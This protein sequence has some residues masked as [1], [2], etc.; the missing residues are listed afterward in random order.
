MRSFE[1][2]IAWLRIRRTL[3]LRRYEQVVHS[4]W[5]IFLASVCKESLLKFWLAPFLR[6][7]SRH[8]ISC[9][10]WGPDQRCDTCLHTLV[11]KF[12]NRLE[13][14]WQL[15]FEMGE[16]TTLLLCLNHLDRL[17]TVSVEE[18]SGRAS[19]WNLRFQLLVASVLVQSLC[20]FESRKTI[21]CRRRL[22]GEQGSR[23]SRLE[24]GWNGFYDH[25]SG[26][27]VP[28]TLY[29]FLLLINFFRFL[30]FNFFTGLVFTNRYFQF[31]LAEIPLLRLL[32]LG[33]GLPS[34]PE[35]RLALELNLD[36]FWQ[37]LVLTF[38]L[39]RRV[40]HG[41]RLFPGRHCALRPRWL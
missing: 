16:L 4:S 20:V 11:G 26:W 33:W 18:R 8:G 17:I 39:L 23:R 35:I 24:N 2:Q 22:S 32:N 1:K 38:P 30:V 31:S 27:T 5:L 41:R 9:R 40:I 6:L 21:N 10:R 36:V 34:L 19:L 37:S 29:Q 7:N 28:T 12:R 25:G 15:I 3:K 13:R 14:C